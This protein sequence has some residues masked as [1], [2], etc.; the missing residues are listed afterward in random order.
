MNICQISRIAE[1]FKWAFGARTEM[2][3][4]QDEDITDFVNE[5]NFNW[6]LTNSD[7]KIN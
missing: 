2:G 5:V 6:Y 1:S 4:P 7:Q 3:D